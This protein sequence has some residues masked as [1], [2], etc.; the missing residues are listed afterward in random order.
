MLTL[1]SRRLRLG[2][3]K[4]GAPP[5]LP[6]DF[7]VRD[8]SPHFPVF[9]EFKGASYL[10]RYDLLWLTRSLRSRL[11]DVR[12]RAGPEEWTRTGQG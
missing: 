7:F 9:P 4:I 8:A 12:H 1:P 2:G 11:A 6:P 3:G 5:T 10:K